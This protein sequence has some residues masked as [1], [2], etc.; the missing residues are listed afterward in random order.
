MHDVAGARAATAELLEAGATAFFT[1]NNLI[2]RGASR[3]SA[4]AARPPTLI[5]FDDFAL[6]E[7]SRHR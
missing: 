4:R 5:G 2:T 7:C 3:C 1:G 6:A